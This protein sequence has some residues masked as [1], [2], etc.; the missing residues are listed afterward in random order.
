M[1]QRKAMIVGL[2]LFMCGAVIFYFKGIVWA[3]GYILSL[4]ILEAITYLTLVRLRKRSPLFIMPK[5]KAPELSKKGLQKFFKQGYDSKLGWIRKPNTNKEEK[6]SFGTTAYLINQKGARSNLEHETLPLKIS[7]YG[8]SFT[9]CR[10]VNDNQTWE[11]FLSELTQSNVANFGVGNYGIDQALLR[12]KREYEKNPTKIVVMG[13]VPS[14]IVR[15][16]SVWKHYHEYGN[17]FGFKPFFRIEKGK[18]KY[19][20]NRIDN[21]D[22]F[23]TYKK[24]IPFFK[25]HDY[26]Y[27]NKFSKELFEFPFF[28]SMLSNPIRN[29][30][31]IT[32]FLLFKNNGNKN[33]NKNE[34]KEEKEVVYGKGKKQ[35][36][37]KRDGKDVMIQK[38]QKI[39]DRFLHP[40]K[41]SLFSKDK[42]VE[43]LKALTQEF[44][45]YAQEKSFTPILLWIPQKDD[46]EYIK[47]R[48]VYYEDYI[49]EFS[50]EFTVVDMTKTLV[51]SNN[52]ENLFT[53]D[54][55]DGGHLSEEGN[56]VVANELFK[57]ISALKT[58]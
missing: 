46:I 25:K 14:T 57:A 2:V 34:S 7:C 37:K 31:L 45:S 28:V 55:S 49:K 13:V 16:L 3:A 52:V 42:P 26:F 39:K 1:E 23:L 35:S 43:L 58:P 32:S 29:I 30:P 41:V 9:F 10:Q 20:A 54:S 51:N 5:D 48:G 19:Y 50:K 38:L 53:E 44:F 33:G 21:E 4:F 22:K 36:D 6:S 11:W 12:L 18:L 40:V 47:R 27:K 56:K 15:I 8:D 24:E 17:T